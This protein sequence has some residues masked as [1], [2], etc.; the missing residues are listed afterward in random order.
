MK[1]IY[2]LNQE[3]LPVLP[4][5]HDNVINRIERDGEVISF[6][7]DANIDDEDDGIRFYHPEA[8]ALIIRYHLMAED[9]YSIYKMRRSPHHL[10]KL[11]PPCYRLLEN[12][13][14]EKLTA[15]KHDL[16]YR[17]HCVGY[18]NIIIQLISDSEVV[19]DAYADY[20]EYEW[21]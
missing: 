14:L 16:E 18:N 2:Y 9:D 8:K 17:Y 11:F 4:T 1:E 12:N 13:M 20:V 15:G 7:L 21:I 3:T 19:I 10:H 5:P 6:Y